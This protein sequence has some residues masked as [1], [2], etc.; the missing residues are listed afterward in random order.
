MTACGD[1]KK[2]LSLTLENPY[3]TVNTICKNQFFGLF[4]KHRKRLNVDTYYTT[5]ISVKN[6]NNK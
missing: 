1:I 3:K 5:I 4:S 2:L 6:N